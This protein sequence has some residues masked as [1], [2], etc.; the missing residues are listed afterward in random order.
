MASDLL[1]EKKNIEIDEKVIE[2]EISFLTTMEGVKTS[3]E[4]EKLES[5]WREDIIYRYELEALLTEDIQIPEDEIQN[6]FNMYKGQYNFDSSIQS[7]HIVVNT[8]EIAEKVIKELEQG[9]SFELLAQE[10][11]KDEET[12]EDGGYLGFLV[13]ESQFYPNRYAEIISNMDEDSY[14]EPFKIG[15]DVAIVYLHRY[16]PEITFTYEEMKPYIENELAL[17]EMEQTLTAKPLWEDLNIEWIFE[18]D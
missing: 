16:L 17:N 14:S 18:E 10:Y 8:S 15:D 11:S 9:A 7:S 13:E 6:Y 4:Q 3:E 5:D 1:S 2:R 12:K